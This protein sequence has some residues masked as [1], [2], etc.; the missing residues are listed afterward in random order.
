MNVQQ[1][2]ST[3]KLSGC[4]FVSFAHSLAG[5]QLSKDTVMPRD[6][7]CLIEAVIAERKAKERGIVTESVFPSAIIASYGY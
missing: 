2:H 4:E 1:F 7:V 6:K 3:L 5:R